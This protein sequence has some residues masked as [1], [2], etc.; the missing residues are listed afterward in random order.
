[1]NS[2]EADDG[3]D[4]ISLAPCVSHVLP[5]CTRARLF[6]FSSTSKCRFKIVLDRI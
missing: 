1:M 6:D 3:D 5:L 4:R 2:E